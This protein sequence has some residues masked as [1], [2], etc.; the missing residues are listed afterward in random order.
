MCELGDEAVDDHTAMHLYLY[1]LKDQVQKPVL[2]QL[3]STFE[4]MVLLAE[5]ADQAY[6]ASSKRGSD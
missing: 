2:L 1:G 5:R 4:E 6:M 3:P